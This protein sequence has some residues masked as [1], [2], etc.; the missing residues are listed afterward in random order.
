MDT[1]LVV[2]A[3]G[4]GSRYGGLKQ[5]DPM[6]PN[7]ELLLDYTVHDAVRA[8]IGRIV[9]VIRSELAE[10]F[11][12]TV[13]SRYSGAA[14]VHYAFQELDDLPAPYRPPA[15]RAKP[16]GTGHAVLAAR[17]HLP[18][19]FLVANADDL[20]GADGIA[21][22]VQLL[23][24]DAGVDP[25][26]AMVAFRLDDT[27]PPAGPVSRG[28]CVVDEQGALQSIEECT[29][30]HREGEAIV[31][32]GEDG[33]RRRFTG[34]EPV[35]MNLWGF[36]RAILPLLEV[37][38][39]EF[40]SRHASEAAAE[41]YLPHAVTDLIRQGLARVQVLTTSSRWLGVTAREDR[42]VVAERLRE[43]VAAGAYPSPLWP[44]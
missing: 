6:G 31:G 42:D 14:Q 32:V 28:V 24:A 44:R 12:A 35:S 38:F 36:R 15:D 9:F 8:G 33:A 23:A 5:L 40:L 17:H 41:F 37:R 1:T 21:A 7:G 16:W 4:L 13:G 19:P 18:G 26:H 43:L 27:L 2:M 10:A 30:L 11:H 29:D 34:E 22:L 20:Y 39:G 3:A 25:P